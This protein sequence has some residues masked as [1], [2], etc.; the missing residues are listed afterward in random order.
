VIQKTFASKNDVTR[1][2][3]LHNKK[4]IKVS[5]S[6]RAG[7]SKDRIPVVARFFA[8]VQTSPGDHLASYINGY[9]VFPAVMRPGRGVDHPP[10]SIAEFKETVE[11]YLYS[12]SG[13]LWPV[14]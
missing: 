11:Q 13:S 2:S 5:D 12:S 7:L 14:L 1:Q 9:R 6:L 8:P 3:E 10:P 4:L